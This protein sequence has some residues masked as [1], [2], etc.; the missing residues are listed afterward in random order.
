MM[1]RKVAH[2]IAAFMVTLLAACGPSKKE[3]QIID[4][5]TTDMEMHCVGRH[6]IELP[7]SFRALHDNSVKLYYGK[8]KDYK[9]VDVTVIQENVSQEAE[10]VRD[11]V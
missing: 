1:L 2:A 5:L 8:D 11:F 4:S 10:S 6:L 3:Q 9:T 7:K